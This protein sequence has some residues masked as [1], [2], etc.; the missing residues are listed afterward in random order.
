MRGVMLMCA[1]LLVSTA[2]AAPV[3]FAPTAA[4]AI[5]AAIL[6]KGGKPVGK[7][8]AISPPIRRRRATSRFRPA[9][10]NTAPS[11]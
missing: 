11:F 7:S 9:A 1:M 2:F 10:A 3:P 5:P 4:D 6:G 8:V